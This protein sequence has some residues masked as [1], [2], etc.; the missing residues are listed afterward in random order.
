MGQKFLPLDLYLFA[1]VSLILSKIAA[2]LDKIDIERPAL[3]DPNQ[4]WE[5]VRFDH[6]AA[7]SSLISLGSGDQGLH[8]FFALSKIVV[9]QPVFRARAYTI[10]TGNEKRRTI[11]KV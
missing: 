6:R 7:S 4:W 9:W 10:E 1:V 2:I 3:R 5:K 8:L 11:E